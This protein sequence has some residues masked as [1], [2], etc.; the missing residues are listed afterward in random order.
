VARERI[1]CARLLLSESTN[2]QRHAVFRNC[3]S[4]VTPI[5]GGLDDLEEASFDVHP[6]P[7][8]YFPDGPH[9]RWGWKWRPSAAK[10]IP[11]SPLDTFSAEMQPSLLPPAWERLKGCAEETRY[12]ATF[13]SRRG[14]KV[15]LAIRGST[16]ERGRKR[17]QG[18][19]IDIEQAA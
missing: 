6:F 3:Q 5:G 1:L 13:R 19:T 11:W 4:Q 12:D 15:L 7:P 14:E 16:S 8:R 17:G 9:H 10:T 2:D 18:M